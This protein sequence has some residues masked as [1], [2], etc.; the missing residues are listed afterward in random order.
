[1]RKEFDFPFLRSSSLHDIYFGLGDRWA[2][3]RL[4]AFALFTQDR[5]DVGIAIFSGATM[6]TT[7]ATGFWTMLVCLAV[8]GIG[9]AMLATSMFALAASY[10]IKYRAAAIGSVNFCLRDRRVLCADSGQRVPVVVQDLARPDDRVRIIRFVTL[11]LIL[12]FVRSWFSETH[13]TA[14]SSEGRRR[15]ADS[16]GT[17]IR[18]C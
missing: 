8:T 16:F 5:T 10:F 1:V 9:M 13:R 6:L 17:G 12:L 4:S 2:A 11:A 14:E 7:V 3:H 18:Y 15:S